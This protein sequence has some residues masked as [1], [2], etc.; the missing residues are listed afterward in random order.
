[1]HKEY[2]ILFGSLADG[3]TFDPNNVDLI[4]SSI[5]EIGYAINEIIEDNPGDFKILDANGNA[6]QGNYDITFLP[7][8]LIVTEP[9]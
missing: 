4:K 3:H 2:S 1:M 6:V 7:G 5:T 8:T 9:N